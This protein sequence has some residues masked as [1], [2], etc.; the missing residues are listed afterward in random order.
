MYVTTAEHNIAHRSTCSTHTEITAESEFFFIP[1]NDKHIT[2][3]DDD[4][5]FFLFRSNYT[6]YPHHKSQM[7]STIITSII[8]DFV[9]RRICRH[10]YL[11]WVYKI[12]HA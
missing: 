11:L 9:S 2:G 12:S 6:F 4:H 3:D 5:H 1:F 8:V 10:A 7:F